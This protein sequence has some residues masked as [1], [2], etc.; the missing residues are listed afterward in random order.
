MP[1]KWPKA[2]SAVWVLKD[3]TTSRKETLSRPSLKSRNNGR[4]NGTRRLNMICEDARRTSRLASFSDWRTF[5]GVCH[6]TSHHTT[7]PADVR[8]DHARAFRILVEEI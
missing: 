8:P 6:A 3:S 7:L 1:R 5:F 4:C 2:T